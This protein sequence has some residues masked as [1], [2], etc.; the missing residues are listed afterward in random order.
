MG[1]GRQD[2]GSTSK[3]QSIPTCPATEQTPDI[4]PAA[5]STSTLPATEQTPTIPPTALS[6]PM[7]PATEQTPQIPAD[8]GATVHDP[9][10]ASMLQCSESAV[11]PDAPPERKRPVQHHKNDQ[12]KPIPE[13]QRLLALANEDG[14]VC[15]A[16]TTEWAHNMTSPLDGDMFAHV[17]PLHEEP[18]A[19]NANDAASSDSSAAEMVFLHEHVFPHGNEDSKI[20]SST[21][22]SL[23]DQRPSRLAFFEEIDG[24][25]C[26]TCYKIMVLTK[27][28]GQR[29]MSANARSRLND[30]LDEALK[31]IR[32]EPLR[33]PLVELGHT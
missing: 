24:P 11:E 1:K 29:S 20:T 26:L 30:Y 13:I 4:P 10:N 5:R 6:T 32:R 31:A 7:R 16:A 22:C 21:V 18:E 19:R 8:A 17:G 27:E 23:C 2:K 14:P 33:T 3:E 15:N 28:V 25:V 9:A 12:E